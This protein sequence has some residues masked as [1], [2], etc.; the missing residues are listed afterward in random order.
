MNYI[1]MGSGDTYV[2][3]KVP[4]RAGMWTRFRYFNLL[5]SWFGSVQTPL[6]GSEGLTGCW[7]DPAV[8]K[9]IARTM[10]IQ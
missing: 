5:L 10:F 2:F 7:L 3:A 6:I 8:C 4:Q 1:Q 9:D